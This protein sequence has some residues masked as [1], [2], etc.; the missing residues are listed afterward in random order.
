VVFLKSVTGTG[1]TLT[2]HLQHPTA[3]FLQYLNHHKVV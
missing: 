3:D 2:Q 1:L